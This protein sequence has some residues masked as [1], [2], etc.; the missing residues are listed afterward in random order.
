MSKIKKVVLAYSGG[1]DTSIMIKWL[2]DN[3]GCEVIAYAADVGQAEELKNLRAKALKTGASKVYLEDLKEEFARDF[4]FPMLK[5]GAVYEN[6]Y[7]LG[8]SVARPLIAQRQVEIAKKEKAD[9]VAHG[10]TGKGNDQVR[11]ELAFKAL[12]PELKI[13][14]PWREWELGGRE[15][16]IEYAERHNIP[17]PVTRK[18][19]YSS[20]RNLWHISY[21][22]GVL[23]DPWF[24]PQEEM[25][26]LTNPPEKAPNRPE[27]VEIE[28][29]SGKP[30]AVSGKRL[31]PVKLIQTLNRI[32]GRHGVGRVDIVENR[33]VGIKSRGVYET[34]GGTV[35]YAAHQALETLTLDRD[36]MHF[37]QQLAQKYAELVY[38]GQWFTP[39]KEALDAFIGRT[40]K[41]VS[42]TV[43][44]KLFKGSCGVVG[45]RAARS[46][47]RPDLAS[48]EKESVYN[49]KD[50]EGF[51]N[52]F[53]LPLKVAA[54]LR[55]GR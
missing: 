40:Q 20:D 9:A 13:I 16:E 47:Y 29:V 42:G 6:Q 12:A 28:F 5:A 2:K 4:V 11:F 51:I 17:V 41:N 25:F 19:P 18:R 31:T 43:R 26:L 37:K 45:R 27:Y 1:L 33:L 48:F 14:A 55:K 39:L 30:V 10:A 21:E 53:G 49:Q 23:E 22:G 8:T 7:L 52:L 44:L 34:P 36:T 50:A 54:L 46:L 32:A 15:E 38:N 35:L 24:E 3:Y